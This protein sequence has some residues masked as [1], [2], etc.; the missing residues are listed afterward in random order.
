MTA[1]SL[2]RI[3]SCFDYR[4]NN[5]SEISLVSEH[6]IFIRPN[7]PW[8]IVWARITVI[9]KKHKLDLLWRSNQNTTL[10]FPDLNLSQVLKILRFYRG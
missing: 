5:L 1:N 10:E 3:R 8:D 2:S 4:G 6:E 9:N 7:A